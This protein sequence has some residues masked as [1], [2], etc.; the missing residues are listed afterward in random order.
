[1]S[2]L[3]KA[4]SVCALLAL[5]TLALTSCPGISSSAGQPSGCT[6]TGFPYCMSW[7]SGTVSATPTN[8]GYNYTGTVVFTFSPAPPSGTPIE[9]IWTYNNGA[10]GDILANGTATGST[11]VSFQVGG[12][13]ISTC[14]FV[15]PTQV[16]AYFGTPGQTVVNTNA[17]EAITTFNWTTSTC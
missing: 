17:T 4:S 14:D 16:N 8:L 15:S 12:S 10:D 11:T 6:A 2:R 13:S 3:I 9:L 1:M 7:T 5:A